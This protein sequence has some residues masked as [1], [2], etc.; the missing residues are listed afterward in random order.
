MKIDWKKEISIPKL[1]RPSASWLPRRSGADGARSETGPEVR[2]PKLLS[3]LYGDLRDRHLLPIVGIL[4]VAMIAAPILLS[5]SG[6]HEE[7]APAI[8]PVSGVGGSSADGTFAVVPA[9]TSL[10]DYKKRLGH[11]EALNPFRQSHHAAGQPHSETG[12][13]NPASGSALDQPAPG[14][15][16][17][18]SVG[19]PTET[20][21]SVVTTTVGGVTTEVPGRES[22]PPAERGHGDKEAKEPHV[23]A[24]EP[25]PVRPAKPGRHGA[26]GAEGKGSPP[27]T[28]SEP[29]QPAVPSKPAEGNGA[30]SSGGSSS[31]V[32][33][34]PT[35][36]VVVGY[37]ID[38]EA[39][40]VPHSTDK[41]EIA[42]M[43]KLPNAKHPVVVFMGLSPDHK[44]ALFL[45]TGEVTAWYGG[46]CA[47]GKQ[48][49]QLVEVGAGKGVTFAYGY[50]NSRYKVHVKQI[51]P[52]FAG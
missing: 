8:A 52:T 49:C 28:P 9:G 44:R 19:T 42:P 18:T 36:A 33:K 46:H 31:E 37:T 34:T 22:R 14:H 17:E 21:E 45:M 3:D 4:L 43:T 32:S 35:P 29:V 25:K 48:A 40:F 47:L 27:A 24:E 13:S 50:G 5:G 30:G 20:A 11:R 6:G 15:S 12:S 2:V 7:E 41:T 38:A 10:R 16:E 23:Q 26:G 39:G 51:V 1:R